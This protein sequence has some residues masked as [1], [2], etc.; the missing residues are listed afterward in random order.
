MNFEKWVSVWGNATS[1]AERRAENYSK[2]LTLRYPIPMVFDG[3]AIRITLSNF[4]GTEA[5]TIA[6]VT[7]A[8]GAGDR[9]IV[10]GTLQQVTFQKHAEATLQPGE[11]LVSDPVVMN[12]RAG[13]PVAVSLYLKDFT[14]MRS[15]VLTTGPLSKG[16]FSVG[17][18]TESQVLPLDDTRGTNWFY[19]LNQVD[20]HTEQENRGIICYGDSITSQAWPDD[21]VLRINALEKKHTAVIR[22][23]VSGTRILHQYHNLIYESYG[24]KGS[25]RFLREM[26]SVQGA[27][28][29][30]IQHGINDIIHP[31]GAEVNPWRPWSDLPSPQELI[32]GL[33]MYIGIAR[34]LGLK[35]YIGTLLPIYGWRTYAPFR[36]DIRNAVN[37]WIRTTD[38]ID[39]YIDFDA[40]LRNPNR[41]EAFAPGFDSGDHLHPSAKAYE[42]MA[43]AVPEELLR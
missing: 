39:G 8:W 10:P 12:I 7:V 17:D 18:C 41:P 40:I 15:A 19:F 38:E 1:I 5:V 32:D 23:A 11:D 25:V 20:V 26:E 28:T 3:D 42:A 30:I 6:K 4:C 37:H 34:E 36:D 33:R 2:N 24:L 22:R 21:L 43:E 31:V 14:E 29:V 27:D 13:Q 9:G 35:V 16:F